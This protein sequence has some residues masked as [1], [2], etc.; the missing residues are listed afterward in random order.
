MFFLNTKLWTCRHFLLQ[1]R[2][3]CQDLRALCLWIPVLFNKTGMSRWCRFAQVI[4][5]DMGRYARVKF[6]NGGL[7]WCRKLQRGVDK[8]SNFPLLSACL[9]T[10]EKW[11]KFQMVCHCYHSNDSWYLVRTHALYVVFSPCK[12]SKW[13]LSTLRG[14]SRLWCHIW[15]LWRQFIWSHVAPV[16]TTSS[17]LLP[18]AVTNVSHDKWFPP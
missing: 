4:M 17:P 7:L 11:Q 13:I 2:Q 5:R 12:K 9:K 6:M 3:R 16:S 15:S 1:I 8:L 18:A 14:V 10:Y